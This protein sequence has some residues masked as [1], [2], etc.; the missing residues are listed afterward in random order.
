MT[1]PSAALLLHGFGG[2]PFEMNPL[3]EALERRGFKVT[4]LMLPGHGRG[5]DELAR[6]G[7]A[8]WYAAA[9]AEYLR[10]TTEHGS[11]CL[12]GASMGGSLCLDVA[13]RLADSTPPA[14]VV[15]LATP[16]WMYRW[17]KGE[18]SDWRWPVLGLLKHVQPLLKVPAPSKESREIAP[19]SGI[20]GVIS[21]KALCSML[22]GLEALRGRIDSVT[23]PLLVLHAPGDSL[24]PLANAW[25]IVSG[26]SSSVRRL[27]LLPI[28]ETITSRHVLTTHR[29][30]APRVVRL[31]PEFFLQALRPDG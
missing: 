12:A 8:D 20:E 3:V 11:V 2:T 10:L 13:A 14:A 30:T 27:E 31:V 1:H 4:N 24:V 9:E 16:L 22:Q 6:T 5:I 15:T 28:Q 29:E 19:W 18:I 7:Y 25:D 21:L 17:R 23:A 26:V